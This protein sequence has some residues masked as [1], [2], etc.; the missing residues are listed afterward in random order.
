MT[1][2][3]T[4]NEEGMLPCNAMCVDMLHAQAAGTRPPYHAYG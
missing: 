1:S 2:F 3:Y 4:C